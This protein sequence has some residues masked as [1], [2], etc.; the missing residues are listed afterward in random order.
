MNNLADTLINIQDFLIDNLEKEMV[1]DLMVNFIGDTY[2]VFCQDDLKI[3]IKVKFRQLDNS[4]KI[5][6]Y[7]GLLN[8]IESIIIKKYKE[9]N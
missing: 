3:L 4:E 5:K 2:K 7:I 8:I 9:V 1:K 6:L